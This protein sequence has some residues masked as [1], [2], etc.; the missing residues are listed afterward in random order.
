M[1]T[2]GDLGRCGSLGNSVSMFDRLATENAA[3]GEHAQLA[4]FAV[5]EGGVNL[6]GE[7][8]LWLRSCDL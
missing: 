2:A 1:A 3:K 4:I 5:A 8:S 6:N 7:N